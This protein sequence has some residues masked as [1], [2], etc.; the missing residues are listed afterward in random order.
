MK[1][2]NNKKSDN[3][4]LNNEYIIKRKTYKENKEDIFEKIDKDKKAKYKEI[5]D[6]TKIFE[7]LSNKKTIDSYLIEEIINSKKLSN[8]KE[9]LFSK[10]T[11]RIKVD[12][13]QKILS[14]GIKRKTEKDLKL[15]ER[16]KNNNYL[17]LIRKH[18]VTKQYNTVS[19]LYKFAIL[20]LNIAFLIKTDLILQRL[21]ISYLSSFGFIFLKM[22]FNKIL[23]KEFKY[24]DFPS[25]HFVSSNI[26]HDNSASSLNLIK[27]ITNMKLLLT[28]YIV[29]R[30]QE[31]VFIFI[32]ININIFFLLNKTINNK[33]IS[34]D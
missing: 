31:K 20:L 1:M 6:K 3:G 14:L 30:I 21:I 32:I 24:L 25:F 34:L 26:I 8:C 9:I 15:T 18:N 22:L 12:N 23:I 29:I 33:K 2:A 4:I 5:K 16:I 19:I 27:I 10:K 17:K 13:W 28:S 7:K 11:P